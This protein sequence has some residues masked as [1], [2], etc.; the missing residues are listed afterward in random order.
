M[1]DD[2][3]KIRACAIAGCNKRMSSLEKDKH[4]VCPGHTGW[5]CSWTQR[6][7]VCQSWSDQDM[8][9]YIR[10][11]EGKARKK[12]CKEKKKAARLA[13]GLSTGSSTA[14]SFSPSSQSSLDIGEVSSIVDPA[15]DRP[16][17]NL[18][19]D[20]GEGI[21]FKRQDSYACGPL[22]KLGCKGS[23]IS[24]SQKCSH[25]YYFVKYTH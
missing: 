1:S 6:C 3:A 22:S 9:A 21:N 11:Q 23:G 4:L 12:A 25:S 16:I 19:L 15:V 18:D 10:L 5:Q 13:A 20:I 14:H 17:D 2:S 7:E 24:T 8:K